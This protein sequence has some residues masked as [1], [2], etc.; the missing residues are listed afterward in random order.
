MAKIFS[1]FVRSIE[2][3][4]TSYGTLDAFLELNKDD[5]KRICLTAGLVIYLYENDAEHIEGE[6]EDGLL[7]YAIPGGL[8]EICLSYS[9]VCSSPRGPLKYTKKQGT[10]FAKYIA[11][12]EKTD[13]S[14]WRDELDEDEA[15][16][17]EVYEAGGDPDEEYY[18]TDSGLMDRDDMD[19][20]ISDMVSAATPLN[21]WDDLSLSELERVATKLDVEPLTSEEIIDCIDVLKSVIG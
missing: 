20:G 17:L 13:D 1:N 6:I 5:A 10:K 15:L 3:L 16:A 21:K 19:M 12:E 9:G 2:E 18:M 7:T 14:G 11:K 4:K 8:A